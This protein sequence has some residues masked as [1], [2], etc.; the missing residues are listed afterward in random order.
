VIH[1]LKRVIIQED[2]HGGELRLIEVMI[3]DQL[4][5]EEVGILQHLKEVD[6]PPLEI[7][8]EQRRIEIIANLVDPSASVAS[9]D[10]LLPS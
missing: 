7:I 9:G 4:S 5:E 1:N 2:G 8:T 3:L 6:N 10:K